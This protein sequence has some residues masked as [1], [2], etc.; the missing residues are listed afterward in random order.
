[1]KQYPTIPREITKGLYIYGFDKL[2]G[3]N[4]RAEWSAKR[5]IY[6]FGSKTQLID[7]TSLLLGDSVKL[8]KDVEEQAHEMLKKQRAQKSMMY[9]EFF[10]ESSFAGNHK[11]GEKKQ[12]KL[13]DMT[14]DNRGLLYPKEFLKVTANYLPTADL[15]YQGFLNEEFINS[16]KNGT[17]TG[18]SFEG[19]ICK[20]N[21]GTP[22]LPVMFKIKNKAWLD[23]LKAFCKEDAAMFERLS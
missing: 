20:A 16:V 22:G 12:V 17:L 14:I 7:E 23:K 4:I 15:L 18:M 1:M 13:I 19:V 11:E 21:Q 5:G 3:S 10:G 8:I 2:D 9:F 6:K